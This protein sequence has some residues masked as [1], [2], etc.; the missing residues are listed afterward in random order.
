MSRFNLWNFFLILLLGAN[1][2]VAAELPEELTT[3]R[4]RVGALE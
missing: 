2:G 3:E 1:L 4:L